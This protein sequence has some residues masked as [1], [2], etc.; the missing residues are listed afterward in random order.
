VLAV[1]LAVAAPCSA[2]SKPPFR[3]QCGTKKERALAVVFR[4]PGG[5]RLVGLL[6]GKGTTGVV[7]GHESNGDLCRWLPFARVLASS[8]YRVLAFDFQDRGLS[9][10]A[11][12]TTGGVDADVVAAGRLMVE[13]GVQKLFVAGAS[14]GG[15]AS[16]VAASRLAPQ[17][18]G[19]ISLSGPAQFG[20][21]DAAAAAPGLAA[22]SLFVAAE[23]NAPFADDARSLFAAVQ[24][25]D[26]Q[27][28]IVPGFAHGTNLLSGSTAAHVRALLLAFLRDH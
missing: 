8:G 12:R 9:G 28:E 3:D 24:R 20:A 5:P 13:R 2:A 27:L 14:M 16:I 18:A 15:T 7:L 19:V 4:Q 25:P 11:G 10:Y 26:K 1:A 23:G 17:L 21:V 6:L 22:P